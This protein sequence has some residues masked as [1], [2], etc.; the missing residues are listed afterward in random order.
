[1][2]AERERFAAEAR[3]RGAVILHEWHRTPPRRLTDER[4]RRDLRSWRLASRFVG[5]GSAPTGIELPRGRCSDEVELTAAPCPRRTHPAHAQERDPTLRGADRALVLPEPTRRRASR[6][7]ARLARARRPPRDQVRAGASARAA[8]GTSQTLGVVAAK[9]AKSA[10]RRLARKH[11]P[12]ASRRGITEWLGRIGACDHGDVGSSRGRSSWPTGMRVDDAT[13]DCYGARA[14][15]G[16]D[17]SRIRLDASRHRRAAHAGMDDVPSRPAS[18]LRRRETRRRLIGIVAA[19]SPPGRR[20][21]PRSRDDTR[22]RIC[23]S[24][25]AT[26]AV[27]ETIR[28]CFATA[29]RAILPAPV[30]ASVLAPRWRRPSRG[31][32]QPSP[33]RG[34]AARAA[35]VSGR[36]A[37]PLELRVVRDFR[38]LPLAVATRRAQRRVG[39]ASDACRRRRR[40]GGS[41]ARVEPRGDGWRAAAS[42]DVRRGPIRVRRSSA[43]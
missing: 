33:A 17:R 13:S 16:A 20:L 37:E 30:S 14:P 12:Q 9:R 21:S 23:R 39:S 34:A 36:S 18:E 2:L 5:A 42:R 27:D 6:N 35:D 1:M 41:R 32:V 43:S 22:A 28:R 10:P 4:Y 3:L 40:Q 38:P 11:V 26:L 24:R 15:A 25:R 31:G 29:V 19:W 8:A 7:A